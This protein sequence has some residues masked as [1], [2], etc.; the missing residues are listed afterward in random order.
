MIESKINRPGSGFTSTEILIRY[1][2]S[3]AD[4]GVGMAFHAGDEE[5]NGMDDPFDLCASAL[6]YG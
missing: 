5:I 1:A 2:T 3:R 6:C 4:I